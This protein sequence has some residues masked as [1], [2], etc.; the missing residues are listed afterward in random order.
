MSKTPTNELSYKLPKDNIAQYRYKNPED[1]RLLVADTKNII[2]FKDLLTVTNEKSVF[3]LNKSKVRNVR[4]KTNKVDTGGKLEIFILNI[5]SDYEYDL[6]MNELIS[7]EKKYPEFS[8][9]TSPSLKVGGKITK[10]FNSFKHDEQ[11]L[12][13][14]NTYSNEDLNDFDKRI[15][16]LLKK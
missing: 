14:G 16:K 9:K 7:L 1:S 12:S 3:V 13:L 11:M 6:K 5:I 10:E 15:K 4:L 8:S 2:K